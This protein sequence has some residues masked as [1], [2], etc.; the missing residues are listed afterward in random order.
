MFVIKRGIHT[1]PRLPNTK[2]LL[3][4]GVPKVLSSSGFK[5]AWTDYQQYLCDKLTLATAGQSL[6]SYHP[7][8]ILLKTAGNPLQSNI[9]NLASSVH[10]N[11]LFMENILPSITESDSDSP[12]GKTE[13]SRLFLSRIQDSF[14]GS[15]WDV[16][17]EE[18]I[19]RSE[20]E[21]LGQGWLFLV[22]NSEKKLFILTCQNNGTPYYF[23]RNQT[24][25]LNSAISIDEFGT[26]K[27]MKEMIENSTKLN[28]K[29]Q[30][31][32]MPLICVNLWDHAYLHDYG[33]GNRSEYV[34]NVLDNLNWSVV[35]NRLFSDMSK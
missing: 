12:I 33:V 6:E 25:D 34:K 1:V 27:Q 3:Q 16:V 13:P 5:V 18:M 14:N 22:E 20:N 35:N 10:N 2:A 15:D 9:F 11:H 32:T 7:F 26:L 17:K 23:P 29:V 21:V 8:H 30:D 28:G 19:H 24:F 31:W 4:K